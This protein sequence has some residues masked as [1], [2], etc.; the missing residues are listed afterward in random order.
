ML[1]IRLLL[2]SADGHLGTDPM[3]VPCL[4]QRLDKDGSVLKGNP[5][6][7]VSGKL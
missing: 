4:L 3:A 6:Y 5:G 7:M 2:G 1:F